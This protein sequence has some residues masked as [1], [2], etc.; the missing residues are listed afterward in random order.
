MVLRFLSL[1]VATFWLLSCSSNSETGGMDAQN[2]KTPVAGELIFE[3]NC[4][5]CH[6][7]DGTGGN[8][9]AKD[10]TKSSLSTLEVERTIKYGKNGMPAILD[11]AASKQLTDSVVAYVKS[12]RN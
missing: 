8:A 5:A 7:A 4:A 2:A 6:G 1:W 11:V 12:L 10:L 3:L 9:D